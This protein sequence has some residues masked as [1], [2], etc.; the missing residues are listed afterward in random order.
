VPPQEDQARAI[1]SVHKKFDKFGHAVFELCKW[2]DRQAGRQTD[3][4]TDTQ[5]HRQ[6]D[7]LI[8][9]IHNPT[10]AK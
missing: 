2:T 9:I 10:R 7:I 4:Q 3:R 1:G 8:T 6:T 5:T